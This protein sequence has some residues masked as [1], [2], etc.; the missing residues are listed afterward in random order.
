MVRSFKS[1]ISVV[2]TDEVSRRLDKALA[3]LIPEE[4]NVSR[5]RVKELIISGAVTN[6]KGRVL[7]D[8]AV[9]PALGQKISIVLP[10][11]V[12]SEILG[13]LFH[14]LMHFFC[15]GLL[16]CS[17]LPGWIQTRSIPGD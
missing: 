16:L 1:T 12:N 9:K 11:A 5:S 2:V 13:E 10:D 4:F 15:L 7:K 6:S 17:G 14:N 8:P 3:Q